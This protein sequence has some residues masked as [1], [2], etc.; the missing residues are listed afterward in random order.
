[1]HTELKD[2]CNSFKEF[3][4]TMYRSAPTCP[5]TQNIFFK[6]VK[7]LDEGSK[8]ELDTQ[9]TFID[10]KKKNALQAMQPNTTPGPDGLTVEFYKHF[11]DRLNRLFLKMTQ[12]AYLKQQLPESLTQ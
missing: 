2:I 5:H 12:E 4:E 1:M 11:F 10:R 9:I 7:P 8:A 6:Y 3:Y